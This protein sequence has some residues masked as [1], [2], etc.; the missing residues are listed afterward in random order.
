MN[1]KREIIKLLKE[2]IA[3]YTDFAESSIEVPPDTKMGDYAFPC[4]SLAKN[5]N[6][7]PAQIAAD[8]KKKIKVK[9]PLLAVEAKG[10]YLNFFL[11]KKSVIEA[12]L[13][14]I[15]NEKEKYGAGAKQKE[16]VMVEFSQ[17]N[18]H[19]EFHIGHLRN[20]CLGDAL[21][22]V[23]SFYGFPVITANYINDTGAHV[24][25]CLWIYKKFYDGKE[26]ENDKGRW[27]GQIY[28]EATKK[29][30]E[31]PQFKAE[32]DEVLQKLES[33][34]PEI[35]RLWEKTK[36]WSM[37]GFMRIYKILN[38]KFDTWFFDN[39]LI[40]PAKRIVEDMKKKGIVVESEGA[41]IADLERFNL[42]K[43]IIL[44]SD[45]TTPY[46]TKDFELA[47]QKFT[48]Y[49]IDR[50]IYVVGVDQRLHFQQLFKI[51]ELYGFKQAKKCYHLSYE[52]VHL[53]EGKMSSRH[54]NAVL[55]LDLY[56][57]VRRKALEEVEKR[58]KDWSK[59]E[60]K[61]AVEQ[62]TLAA[63]KFGMVSIENNKVIIF[64][65]DKALDFEGES[66]PYIQYTHARI[67][68]IIKKASNK[69]KKVD[70]SLLREE[71]EYVIVKKLMQFPN[72]VE[73]SAQHYKVHNIARY[74]IELC[75]LFNNYYHSVKVIQDDKEV[76]ASRLALI[77]AV[78]HVIR[79]GLNLLGIPSPERM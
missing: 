31:N 23:L 44:K 1:F 59:D 16:K 48:K 32:V 28:A 12:A 50:S 78:R 79:N 30:E 62:I 65:P 24:A 57:L 27:L 3:K 70:Y 69:Q 25:K 36:K 18:T 21:S 7:N 33:K 60:K 10:P 64:D 68:S 38:V 35:M 77:N 73:E 22:K 54:G 37:E 41:L 43:V 49:K 71:S 11:D 9:S 17:P 46:I 63:L 29:V 53:K 19:K 13:K 51:L 15:C 52:L 14:K 40:E 2:H 66:G 34:D 61:K 55:F 20:C 45:G 26:P 6:K 4:F 56:E 75:Q 58:H 42:H 8:L 47:N 76:E 67:C 5:L 74:L 72:I 39:E